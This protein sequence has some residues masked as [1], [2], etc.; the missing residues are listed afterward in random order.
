MPVDADS[1][2][3]TIPARTTAWYEPSTKTVRC[4]A[5][6]AGT[7]VAEPPGT[8]DPRPQQ[9]ADSGTAGSSARREYERRKAGEQKRLRAKWGRLGRLAVI[10]AGERQSTKAWEQ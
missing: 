5:C 1:A 7:E 4:I 9:P 3:P 6:Q 2:G 8:V 10:L